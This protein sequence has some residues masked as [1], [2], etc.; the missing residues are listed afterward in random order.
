MRIEGGLGGIGH[1]AQRTAQIIIRSQTAGWFYGSPS[2]PQPARWICRE[3]HRTSPC[4]WANIRWKAGWRVCAC[5]MPAPLKNYSNRSKRCAASPGPPAIIESMLRVAAL[6]L[7]VGLCA[8]HAPA[9]DPRVLAV[10]NANAAAALV[11]AG[12]A[13]T[14]YPDGEFVCPMDADVRASKPGSCPRCG[15]KLV[16]GIMDTVEYPVHLTVTPQVI[17]PGEEARLNFDIVN[18]KTLKPARDHQLAET[19]AGQEAT[20][21]ARNA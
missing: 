6:V 11:Q 12:S 15:M 16:E 1:N 20:G 3:N 13:L 9:P 2:G 21:N 10:L 7:V 18:P 4:A 14:Q 5:S 19:C 17:H 8:W